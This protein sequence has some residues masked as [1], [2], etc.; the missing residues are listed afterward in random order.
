[1]SRWR[2]FYHV[3]WATRDRQPLITVDRESR[4]QQCLR[5]TAERLDIIVHAVGGTDDHVHLAV[6]I[7]PRIAISDAMHRIKGASSRAI[8]ETFA[9][10]FQW[11]ADYNIDS[12]SERHLSRV[13]GYIINQWRHHADG[14]R[15][16]RVELPSN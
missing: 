12:F 8:N 6:S 4:V 7:P 5:A 11:Q 14:V 1:M 9:G 3:V 10:G 16:E 15:W 2:L 13:V